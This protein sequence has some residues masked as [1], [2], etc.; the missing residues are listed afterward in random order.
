MAINAIKD[1]A[2]LTSLDTGDTVFISPKFETRAAGARW[3]EAGVA[4]A[5]PQPL[6]FRGT[7]PEERT[8]HFSLENID[9]DGITISV[10]EQIALLKQ[11]SRRVQGK[12]RA[13]ILFY[14]Y[15]SH[16]FRCVLKSCQLSNDQGGILI[17]KK[18]PR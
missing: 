1:M 5:S 2:K 14:S 9:K 13:H 18:L 15:N 6:E 7:I 16:S 3:E 17:L 12:G 11:F 10:E 8:I 4:G